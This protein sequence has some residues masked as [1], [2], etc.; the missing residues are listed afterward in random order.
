M[1]N[2]EVVLNK[3]KSIMIYWGLRGGLV[4]FFD[5]FKFNFMI[6][7]KVG[8]INIIYLFV[9]VLVFLK[10]ILRKLFFYV[11]VGNCRNDDIIFFL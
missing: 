11:I 9:N 5:K 8:I 7:K 10:R 2:L 4:E 6:C 1:Y 3:V